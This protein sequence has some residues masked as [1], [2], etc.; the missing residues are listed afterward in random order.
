MLQYLSQQGNW[1][2]ANGQ[3]WAFDMPSRDDDEFESEDEDGNI[4]TGAT[5]YDR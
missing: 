2:G 4:T 5:P 3:S 1:R